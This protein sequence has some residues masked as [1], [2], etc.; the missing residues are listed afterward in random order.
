MWLCAA[1]R[2]R[3]MWFIECLRVMAEWPTFLKMNGLDA[4]CKI[5]LREVPVLRNWFG[6]VWVNSRICL[7]TTLCTTFFNVYKV[8]FAQTTC[9]ANEGGWVRRNTTVVG[10]Y[11][12]VWRL[13]VS[14][15]LGHLQVI[16]YFIINSVVIKIHNIYICEFIGADRV[17]KSLLFL[18]FSHI[19]YFSFS[20]D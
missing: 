8:H 15:V 11:L 12:L 20:F 5:R 17:W 16:S 7:L 14:A 19:S 10:S 1:P 4:P 9:F 13:H 3:L 2:G 18:Y 6:R